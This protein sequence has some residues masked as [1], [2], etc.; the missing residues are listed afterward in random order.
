MLDNEEY[1]DVVKVSVSKATT[2]TLVPI[3]LPIKSLLP[4][5]S[6]PIQYGV[7]ADQQAFH[8]FFN[9]LK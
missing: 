1:F 9:D 7:Q 2:N 6:N 8:A 5:S 4:W 3:D